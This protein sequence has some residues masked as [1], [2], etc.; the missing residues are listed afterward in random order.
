MLF[1]ELVEIMV[2]YKK[3]CKYSMSILQ[4]SKVNEEIKK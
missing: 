1:W 2:K 4:S 3:Q